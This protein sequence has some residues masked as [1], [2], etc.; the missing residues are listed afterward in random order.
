MRIATAAIA[1]LFLAGACTSVN[2]KEDYAKLFHDPILFSNTVHE[3][4]SVVMG[5][6]FSPIVASRNYMYASVAAYEVIAAGYPDQYTSLAGQLHGLASIPK[7][8][9]TKKVDFEFASVLAFAKLGEAV[10]FPEGSMTYY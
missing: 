5:N 10:T 9:T 3:L 7:A 8:D 6:N 2:K 1:I 4:N